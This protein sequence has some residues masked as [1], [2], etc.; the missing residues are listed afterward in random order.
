M[1]EPLS[2]EEREGF[3]AVGGRREQGVVL[4]F[5]AR[6]EDTVQAAEQR[7]KAL[8]SRVAHVVRNFALDDPEAIDILEAALRADDEDR[9]A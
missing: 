5:A 6:Y 1:P 8:R 4:E 9:G 7:I 2:R 3:W